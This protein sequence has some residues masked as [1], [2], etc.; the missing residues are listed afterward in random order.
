MKQR[1]VSAAVKVGGM[2]LFAR[3][4]DKIRKHARGELHENH[5]PFLGLGFDQRLCRFFRVSYED[6]R[7]RVL[8]GGSDDEIFAWCQ[9]HGRGLDENDL[10]IWNDFAS[11]R[12]RQ[13]E[14]TAALEADKAKR[15][16][17][18]R[19]DLTTFFE[20]YEV[21]EGRAPR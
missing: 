2:V 5:V 6:L 3:V 7:T 14:T 12:G 1:P 16:L 21:D 15:G 20:F 8:A 10:L 17:A 11:K 19:T 18:H 4:L 13:D 9:Q